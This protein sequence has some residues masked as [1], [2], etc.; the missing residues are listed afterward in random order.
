MTESNESELGKEVI[1]AMAAVLRTTEDKVSAELIRASNLVASSE[2]LELKLAASTQE[3]TAQKLTAAEAELE[4]IQAELAA[5]KEDNLANQK[6]RDFH[7]KYIDSQR[8]TLVDLYAKTPKIKPDQVELFRQLVTNA[9]SELIEALIEK[10][11]VSNAQSYGVFCKKCNSAEHLS[12]QRSQ[13]NIAGSAEEE[14]AQ[15]ERPHLAYNTNF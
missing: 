7:K 4:K 12:A 3:T 10:Q 1:A 6:A 13:D 5:A 9:S 2:L 8:E 15:I 14:T 11:G